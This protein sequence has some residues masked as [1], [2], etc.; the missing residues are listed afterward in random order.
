MDVK[1]GD[2][3]D[4]TRNPLLNV[5]PPESLKPSGSGLN[6]AEALELA[7]Q[8]YSPNTR[9]AYSRAFHQLQQWAEIRELRDLESFDTLKLLAYK[10]KMR[11]EG[12]KPATIN[13]H[14]SAVRKICAVLHEIGHLQKNP[15]D[16]RLIR[17]ER[18]AEGSKK[19]SLSLA[20]LHAMIDANERIEYDRRNTN[21]LKIRNALLL[22]FLYLTA[23]QRSEAANLKWE[24]LHQ[25]GEFQV[26]IL[27][28]T[29]SGEPQ[30][31]KLRKELFEE[32]QSWQTTLKEN[33]INCEWVFP[34]LSFRTRGGKMS[35]KGV[36]DV[37]SRLGAAIGLKISAHYLR[38]TAI[39]L[40]LELGEPLQKVQSYARHASANTTIRYYHDHQFLEKNPTDR[41]PM[42]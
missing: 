33:R 10:Q 16:T 38:H 35:G 27:Q 12:R 34:S 15:F 14:L 31:L 42:I 32:L 17:T 18:V 30:K 25:D 4:S 11:D 24:D 39:T 19:G 21:L 28:H 13:L 5:N 1:E 20:Q 23:A 6:P 41:L 2:H 3:P 8:E 7:F 9:R 29:K 37:I 36:N 26:V 22:K 40:A